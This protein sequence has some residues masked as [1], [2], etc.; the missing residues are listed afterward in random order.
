MNVKRYIVKDMAEAMIKI[1]NELG[2][3][4]IILSSRKIKKP[5]IF[6]FFKKSLLEVVAAIDEVDNSK[7]KENLN[8]EELKKAILKVKE[9]KESST[10]G[11]TKNFEDNQ[12]KKEN[13]DIEKI[14]KEISDLKNLVKD[15]ISN[16]NTMNEDIIEEEKESEVKKV[17]NK[18][19]IIIDELI[20]RDITKENALN[21]INR[22]KELTK[23]GD[24]NRDDFNKIF[25]DIIDEII[26]EVYTIE[27]DD[28][29]KIFFFVGPTGVGKTTTLAKLAARLSLVDNKKIAFITADTYRIA[30]VEQLRTYSE[31]LGIPLSVVYEPD[32]ID[33]AIKK[34]SDMDYILVDTAG[35]N[36]KSSDLKTD[37]RALLNKVENYEVFL[38]ISLT[39]GY[40]DI[41]SIINSYNFIGEYKFIFTKLDEASSLANV[42]NVKLTNKGKLSYFTIGQSVPD[43]IEIASSKRL[44]EFFMGVK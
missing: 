8:H 30:A 22:A 19:K 43:D 38:V 10:K 2:K 3:D 25:N 21:I 13:E 5:G 11:V 35:R 16:A 18:E 17:K 14:N 12:N 20:E 33:D 9:I 34:Y 6:G 1:K 29:Q 23:K 15:F 40:K 24:I 37:V 42:I 26:G 7:E 31:I 41:I 44:K 36:H 32:E 4:A 28:A 39:T 27:K